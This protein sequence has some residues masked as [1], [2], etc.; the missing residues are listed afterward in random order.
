MKKKFWKSKTLI[1]AVIA[2][3]LS[4]YSEITGDIPEVGTQEAVLSAV[5]FL[6]RIVTKEELTAE[7]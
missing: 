1:A 5:F 6:L 7:L 2:F 3:G 4:V